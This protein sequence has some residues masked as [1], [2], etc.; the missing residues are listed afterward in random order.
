MRDLLFRLI[1]IKAFCRSYLRMQSSMWDLSEFRTEENP[2]DTPGA[3]A[4]DLSLYF[5]IWCQWL[6]DSMWN[7]FC[8]SIRVSSLHSQRISTKVFSLL[9]RWSTPPQTSVCEI[10][11]DDCQ[12]KNFALNFRYR[13]AHF[14][15][16]KT[17]FCSR[18]PYLMFT[19]CKCKVHKAVLCFLGLLW[20]RDRFTFF[21]FFLAKFRQPVIA[22]DRQ[23]SILS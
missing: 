8:C 12:V 3:L 16:P 10:V 11:F 9:F 5:Y 1:K 17:A 4:A 15:K 14:E 23:Q 6:S 20:K 7:G 2:I 13:L 19:D 21:F 18:K 22:L